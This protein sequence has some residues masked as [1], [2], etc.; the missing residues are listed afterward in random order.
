M[1]IA[2]PFLASAERLCSFCFL[3]SPSEPRKIAPHAPPSRAG[4]AAR[5]R[6][7]MQFRAA[8]LSPVPSDAGRLFIVSFFVED[9]T[10]M[11][12]ESS[13]R[14]SGRPSATFAARVSRS[15][16]FS[17]GCCCCCC[18]F[19]FEVVFIVFFFSP[20]RDFFVYSTAFW[21]LSVFK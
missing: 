16:E 11:V 13:P 1:K 10:L 6:F 18:S 17:I 15:L 4:G 2:H 21:F 7:K 14:N 9:S 19:R 8:M 5:L 3:L 12:F 20:C